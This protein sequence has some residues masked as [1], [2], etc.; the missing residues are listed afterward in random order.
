M[1]E[2]GKT[3]CLDGQG[4]SG[5]LSFDSSHLLL[6]GLP[7]IRSTVT[8]HPISGDGKGRT[9]PT[10][11]VVN[12]TDA[13]EFLQTASASCCSFR[14]PGRCD[15]RAAGGHQCPPPDQPVLG[16][17]FRVGNALQEAQRPEVGSPGPGCLSPAVAFHSLLSAY[18]LSP[19]SSI[20]LRYRSRSVRR[21]YSRSRRRR[22]TSLSSPWRL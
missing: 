22:P 20:S 2:F 4:A 12:D 13:G 15:R 9:R 16:R 1:G 18:F 5:E 10:G 14:E 11:R 6:S 17:P 8:A 3:S 21:R 19:R 7:G